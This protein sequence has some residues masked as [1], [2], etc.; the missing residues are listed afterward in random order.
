M[1]ADFFTQMRSAMTLQRALANEMA[2]AKKDTPDLLTSRDVLRFATIQGARDL[3]I[4]RK[5][6]SL[7]PGKEAD[8]VLLRTSDLNLHPANSPEAAVLHAHAANVDSVFVSGKALKRHG[9]LT[10]VDLDRAR[11]IARQSRDALYEKVN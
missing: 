10:H 1:T 8:I 4:D 9:R 6:G 3:K 7:T 2:I 5:A 11:R